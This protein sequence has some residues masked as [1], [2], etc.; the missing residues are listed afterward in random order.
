MQFIQGIDSYF[1]Y[2]TIELEYGKK[3]WDEFRK[4][5]KKMHIEIRINYL[6]YDII[7]MIFIYLIKKG[8]TLSS[9]INI[10][11]KYKKILFSINVVIYL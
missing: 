11:K 10:K 9:F 8:K 7:W 3:K 2:I 6:K 1:S 5:A 4:N